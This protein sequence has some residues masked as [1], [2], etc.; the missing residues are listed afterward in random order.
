LG[1]WFQKFLVLIVWHHFGP[2]VT[3]GIMVG[4]CGRGGPLTWWQ[5]RNKEKRKGKGYAYNIPFKV[6]PSD[7]ISSYLLKVSPHPSGTSD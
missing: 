3:W 6:T 7:L 1:S 2:G 4:V 5:L